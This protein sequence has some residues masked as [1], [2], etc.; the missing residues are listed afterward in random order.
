[1]FSLLLQFAVATAVTSPANQHITATVNSNV[2]LTC[3]TQTTDLER[4]RWRV[5]RFEEHLRH[6]V[7]LFNSYKVNPKY[8][9]VTVKADGVTERSVLTIHDLQYDDAGKYWCDVSTETGHI[10]NN[11]TL[12]VVG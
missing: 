5:D 12:T 8:P 10:T 4:I 6:F 3:T 11:F 2:S 9:R 7:V 1:M